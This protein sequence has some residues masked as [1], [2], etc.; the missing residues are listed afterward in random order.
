MGRPANPFKAYLAFLA[1]GMAAGAA[2]GAGGWSYATLRV[3]E[4]YGAFYGSLAFSLGIILVCV[5]GLMLYTGKIGYAARDWLFAK[6]GESSR[7]GQRMIALSIILAG[8][9]AGAFLVGLLANWMAPEATKQSIMSIVIGKN[10]TEMLIIFGK[11][12]LCGVLVYAGV[13]LYRIHKGVLGTFLVAVC[14]AAFVLLGFDHCVANAFYW[15]GAVGE[16]GWEYPLRSIVLCAMGNSI[17]ALAVDAAKRGLS[18]IT[19]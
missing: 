17:G 13:D 5:C 18:S 4:P 9:V 14:I 16:A 2:I 11:S 19:L 6:P 3:L 8:N 10:Q 12:A 7:F 15:G 1:S